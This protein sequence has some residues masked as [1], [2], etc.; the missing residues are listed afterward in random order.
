MA[1]LLESNFANSCL[2]DGAAV[3]YVGYI[4]NLLI[5][6]YS[7]CRLPKVEVW[8]FSAVTN[9]GSLCTVNTAFIFCLIKKWFLIRSSSLTLH[10]GVEYMRYI[11]L[12][13]ILYYVF[14]SAFHVCIKEIK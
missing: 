9:F 8:I 12:L 10:L 11:R 3:K 7:K 2:M 13:Q 1:I 14:C 5:F 4:V 6:R